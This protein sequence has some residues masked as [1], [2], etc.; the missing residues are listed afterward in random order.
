[1]SIA[2]EMCAICG[3]LDNVGMFAFVFEGATHVKT[4]VIFL[5]TAATVVS[6][7]PLVKMITYIWA[8]TF[9]ELYDK[10][11]CGIVSYETDYASSLCP[12]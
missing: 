10:W 8:S 6:S 12:E 5:N 3:L 11:G 1:M 2:H 7:A 4:N 9:R